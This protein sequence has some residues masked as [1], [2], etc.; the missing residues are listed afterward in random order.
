VSLLVC[1]DVW[2]EILIKRLSELEPKLIVVPMA[3]SADDDERGRIS[4]THPPRFLAEWKRRFSDVSAR[5]ESAL[6][7]VNQ[8]SE[9][10][11]DACGA[12]GGAYAFSSSGALLG[13]RSVLDPTPLVVSI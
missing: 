1:G 7:A 10:S 6:V 4:A 2:E 3:F 9:D 8:I 13:E 5:L 11:D 12:C